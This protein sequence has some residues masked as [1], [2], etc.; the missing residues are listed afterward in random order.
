MCTLNTISDFTGNGQIRARQQSQEGASQQ[1]GWEPSNPF[2]LSFR[3][4]YSHSGFNQ[5]SY[6]SF[7]QLEIPGKNSVSWNPLFNSGRS[8]RAKERS[9]FNLTFLKWQPHLHNRRRQG[10]LI[11]SWVMDTKYSKDTL[12]IPFYLFFYL[13]CSL[14]LSFF[15]ICC[16]IPYGY[17]LPSSPNIQ[18]SN[19]V[20]SVIFFICL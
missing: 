10:I 14:C 15:V 4:R 18:T 17:R 11:M 19:L 3:K 8:Q 16:C 12:T 1:G 13:I 20:A 6:F 9:L 2:N 5:A 7:F